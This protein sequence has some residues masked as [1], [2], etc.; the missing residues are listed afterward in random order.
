MKKIMVSKKF[1]IEGLLYEG[2][3]LG[4]KDDRFSSFGGFQRWKYNP[5]EKNCYSCQADWDDR[6]NT[7]MTYSM[8]KAV[9]IL[10]HNRDSLF[11]YTKELSKEQKTK[12]KFLFA[13]K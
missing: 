9:K 3:A 7:I 8:K 4:L 10:W 11:L 12:I 1:Q 6:R 13:N 2:Y 5:K